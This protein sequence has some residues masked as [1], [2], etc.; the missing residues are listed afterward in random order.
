MFPIV[1]SHGIARFDIFIQLVHD[2]LKLPPNQQEDELQYFKN[3]RTFLNQNGF[4]QV[5]NSN[6]EFAGS[7]ETRAAEL[8][9]DVEDV[10]AQTGAAPWPRATPV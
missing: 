4:S 6:V 3:V 9:R 5:F 10:L 1:L 8:K 7:L 2:E